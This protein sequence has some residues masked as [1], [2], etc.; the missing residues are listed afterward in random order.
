[1]K[2]IIFTLAIF[3]LAF[4]A[5]RAQE[6]PFHIGIKAGVNVADWR[7]DAV[8]SFSE[9]ADMTSIMEAQSLTGFHV[10]AYATIPLSQKFAIEPG[11]YYSTKG[12]KV[13]QTL[14]EGNFLNLKGEVSSKLTYIE[15]PIL[16]KVYLVKGLHV[17][18]GPQV[19]YLAS[20]KVRAEAGILGFSVGQDF[21][22]NGGFRKVDF[23]V[24][25]GLGYQFSN[26]VNLSAGYEHGLSTLDEGSS[27]IDAYN[28]VFKFSL[29]YTF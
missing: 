6:K 12:M 8:E 26:G 16:A 22:I 27:Q 17:F 4:Q 15:L 20:N 2:K 5:A 28:R 21:D 23:A 19:S 18:A 29:G 1:M 13:A 9:L 7:G 3:C 14:T 24:T 10:G 11:L 25:G